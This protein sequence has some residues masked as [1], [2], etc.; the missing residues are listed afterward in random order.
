MVYSPVLIPTLCRYDKFIRCFESLNNNTWAEYTDVYIALDYP[1]KLSH[2]EGYLKIKHYCENVQ[3]SR[4]S[5][6]KSVSI[7]Y[8]THNCGPIGNFEKLVNEIF[9]KYDSCICTF[10][11]IEHSKNFIQYMDT[12]LDRFK[13]DP[14]VIMVNGYSYPVE[15]STAENCTAVM[16]NLEGN[17]W[18]V[19]FWK[20]KW[21]DFYDFLHK[22]QLIRQFPLML[23]NGSFKNMTDWA[24]KDYVEAVVN[25]VSFNSLLKRITDVSLRIYLSVAGKFSIMPTISKTRNIG[26][27]G[28]GAFCEEV[29]YDSEKE[30]TSSNYRFDLQPIDT[31]DT[32]QARVDIS[33][34][35]VCNKEIVNRFDRRPD[36]EREIM[37]AKAE[38]YAQASAL[39]HFS[40]NAKKRISKIM[41]RIER[42]VK[43]H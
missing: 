9:T 27:D 42:I 31:S 20:D 8:R 33:F 24:I 37:I 2:K 29:L 15:W 25:G 14:S 13:D 10:D 28:S 21:N 4:S 39:N 7:I 1:N 19:G 5:H 22:G 18:G 35:N 40:Q 12:M 11:D 32:F 43:R 26:F 38:K 36:G 34:D 23:K 6:F 17:I 16:Q 30:K 3:N 41:E